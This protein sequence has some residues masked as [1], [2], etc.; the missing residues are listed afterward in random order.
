M[1]GV[2]IFISHRLIE[3]IKTVSEI[4]KRNFRSLTLE[5]QR[6]FK[7]IKPFLVTSIVVIVCSLLDLIFNINKIWSIK[8]VDQNRTGMEITLGLIFRAFNLVMQIYIFLTVRSLSRA[9][10]AGKLP[11]PDPPVAIEIDLAVITTP[12]K[13]KEDSLMN[14]KLED[15]TKY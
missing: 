15:K 7:K 1:I 8:E 13:E 12:T 10:E 6:D 4:L 14:V 9:M 11:M 2:L 3:G 5:F